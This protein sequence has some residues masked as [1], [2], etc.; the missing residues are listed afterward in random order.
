MNQKDFRGKRGAFHL[1]CQSCSADL[2]VIRWDR[3]NGD[4]EPTR[5][6]YC[7]GEDIWYADEA[8]EIR[9]S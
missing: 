5:C 3:T 7:G 9:S 8:M 4:E 6:P 2:H 1:D